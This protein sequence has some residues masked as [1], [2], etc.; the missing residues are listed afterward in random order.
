[1]ANNSLKDVY[2]R[3][4]YYNSDYKILI[5]KKHSYAIKK[6]NLK[7]H[8]TSLYLGDIDSK[9]IKKL[10]QFGLEQYRGESIYPIEPIEP[11]PYLKIK[12][13]TFQCL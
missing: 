8:F 7:T 10:V 9:T 2:N 6:S 12:D 4:F 11:I 13:P 3:L 5:C 1:M